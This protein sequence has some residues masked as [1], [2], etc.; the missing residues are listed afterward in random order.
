[1]PISLAAQATPQSAEGVGPLSYFVL[2]EGKG[3][4]LGK[5]GDSRRVAGV[6]ELGQNSCCEG[7]VVHSLLRHVAIK[8]LVTSEVG[9]WKCLDF[10]YYYF[11]LWW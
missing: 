1:M 4:V 2:R 6:K 3:E 5:V 11:C 9:W 8:Q 7:G 10:N